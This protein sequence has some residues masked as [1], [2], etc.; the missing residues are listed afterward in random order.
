MG[1]GIKIA[2]AA[3]LFSIISGGYFF[4]KEQQAQLELAKEVQAK[5]EGVIEKQGLAMDNMKADMERMGQV[6]KELS[7]SI[8][9]AEKDTKALAK[10]FTEDAEGRER[11]LAAMAA[12][13]PSVV[14]EKINRGTKDALRCN[15]LLTGAPLTEDEKAGK[16]RNNI[17]ADLLPK[18]EVKKK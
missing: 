2:I 17:C 16:V 10:K 11:N 5:M 3:I 12:E 6:Q 15:E 4:I 13:K 18:P 1:I 7:G 14:E 9:A 8:N